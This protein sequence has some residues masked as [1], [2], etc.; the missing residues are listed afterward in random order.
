MTITIDTTAVVAVVNGEPTKS[1]VVELTTGADVLAPASLPWEV[2]NAYSAMFKKQ[3]ATEQQAMA[4]LAL[5]RRMTI[6][7]VDVS[8]EAAVDLSAKL[9]IYAYDAY[10]LACAEQTGTPLLTLD[11]SLRHAAQRLGLRVLQVVP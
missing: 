4:A 1:R 11:R 6:R 9:G 3:T 8:L 5:Y 7:L 10:V 2:G